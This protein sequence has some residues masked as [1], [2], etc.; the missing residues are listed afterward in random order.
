MSWSSSKRLLERFHVCPLLF[1]ERMGAASA[2][3]RGNL[4]TARPVYRYIFSCPG[5]AQALVGCLGRC[6]L[7]DFLPRSVHAGAMCVYSAFIQTF[8]D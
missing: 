8:D 1:R 5:Q 6:W 3:G 4:R 7:F 2:L